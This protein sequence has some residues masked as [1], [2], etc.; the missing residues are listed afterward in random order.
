MVKR[1]VLIDTATVDAEGFVRRIGHIDLMAIADPDGRA[2]LETAGG[3]RGQ[4]TLPFF[5]IENVMAVDDTHIMVGVDNNLPFSSGRALDKAAD[6][7]VVLLAVPEMLS[8]R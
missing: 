8:A 3:T 6:N 2:R 7:E 1:V 5:T 4:F